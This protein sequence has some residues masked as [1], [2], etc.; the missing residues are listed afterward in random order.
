MRGLPFR[1]FQMNEAWAQLVLAYAK[2]LRSCTGPQIGPR[3]AP[4]S[5]TE[6]HTITLTPLHTLTAPL[7]VTSTGL[8]QDLG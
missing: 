1:R 7:R 8:L 6:V 2:A 5:S 4:W 3:M